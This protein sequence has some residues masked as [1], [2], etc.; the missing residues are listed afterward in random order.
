MY[1]EDDDLQ[2]NVDDDSISTLGG[3]D[4]NH[5][6]EVTGESSTSHSGS[7]AQRRDTT[8]VI[9]ELTTH[10]ARAHKLRPGYCVLAG[11]MY[12]RNNSEVRS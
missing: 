3:F 7:K 1:L 2:Q 6:P 9:T 4:F 10:D 5:D 11:E 12:E 8:G